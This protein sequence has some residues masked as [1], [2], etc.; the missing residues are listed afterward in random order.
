MR[1]LFIKN[2][3]K[4]LDKHQDNCF[5]SHIPKKMIMLKKFNHLQHNQKFNL[6]LYNNKAFNKISMK[7]KN[8]KNKPKFQKKN[9]LR[10][11]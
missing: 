11:I 10:K 3:S 5:L 7:K 8:N 9:K 6:L 4:S 2:T 1:K